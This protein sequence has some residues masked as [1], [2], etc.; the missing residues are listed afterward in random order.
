MS[1][2]R[3]IGLFFFMLLNS[4]NSVAIE[5]HK[6]HPNHY[7]LTL[8]EHH[9]YTEFN[10]QDEKK[11]WGTVTKS[12]FHIGAHYDSYDRF[13]L[14]EGRGTCQFFSLGTLYTWATEIDLYDDNGDYVGLI[15]GEVSSAKSGKFRFF[16]EKGDE[17][18]V[19]HLDENKTTFSLWDAN[20]SSILLATLI[21]NRGEES[22]KNWEIMIY[23]PDQISHHMVKIFAAF[24]CDHQDKFHSY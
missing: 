14:Y 22:I 12:F 24:V 13:G 9:F 10:I 5:E 8:S 2:F 20:D 23:R 1:S 4:F 18:A 17:F 3:W 16:N 21:L 15:H 11:S 7:Y 6:E 19:G